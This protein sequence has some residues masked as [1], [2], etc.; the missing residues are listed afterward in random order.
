MYGAIAILLLQVTGMVT[1]AQ[2]A[3]A[4][5][6]SPTA[7]NRVSKSF[8]FYPAEGEWGDYFDLTIDAGTTVTEKVLIANTGEITN[9][10]RTYATNAFTKQGGGFAAAEYGTEPNDV[11]KWLD[12]PEETFDIEVGQGV[13]R[14]FTV[15]VPPGTAPGEYITAIAAANAEAGGIEGTSE[16]NQITRYVIPVLITVPGETTVGFEIGNVTLTSLSDSLLIQIP[17]TNTGDVRVRPKGTVDLLSADG[18]LVS[19]FPVEMESIY[20]HDSTTLTLGINGSIAPG[21]YQVRVTFADPESGVKAETLATDLDFQGSGDLA[22]KTDFTISTAAITP[23]PAADNVQFANV[24]AVIS[25]IGDPV[26]NA[27]LSLIASVDGE[28]VE[29]FPISQSLS[30]PTG[31]TPITTRY[32][33]ATG[34]TSGSWTFELLLETVEPGG[35][36]VVV[37][38]QPIEGA[39]VIP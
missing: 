29:R 2:E 19:S 18:T 33:P 11:T 4:T 6:A 22:V 24:E 35:A 16:L 27:Q 32:I 39:I 3:P 23:G 28:E 37:G 15:T 25:N 17:L 14:T 13:E 30:L 36:A 38:R 1:D 5:P 26:G 21:T 9:D 34:W 8:Q 7:D 10:L 12:Y 20:A 31:D